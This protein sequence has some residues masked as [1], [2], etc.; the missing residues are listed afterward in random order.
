M[1]EKIYKAYQE[2][3]QKIS[4]D[5]RKVIPGSIFFA[6]K[7]E[8]F[9]GNKFIS[10]AFEKG[11]SY[12][13]IDNSAYAT[14]KTFLVDDV[15][16]TLQHLANYHRKNY[17]F[18]IIAITGTNGKTTTKE[19]IY[20]VLSVKYKCSATQGNL[21]NHL[22]VPLT[23]LSA[24]PDTEILIV[25]MGANHI[26]EIKSLCEIANPDM[27]IITNIGR[28][29]LEGFGGF[30]NVIKAKSELYQ[31]LIDRNLP[32]FV[33]GQDKLL[34]KIIN[35]YSTL[36]SYGDSTSPCFATK[37]HFNKTLLLEVS[38][39]N[40]T[41]K[42]STQ[43][44]GK[45]NIDNILAALCIGQY[46]EVD[47][48]DAIH[49][50]EN[51][52]PQNNRSQIKHTRNNTL[53]LDGYNANP[54]SMN[55]ALTSFLEIDGSRKMVIIG[56]MNELGKYSTKEHQILLDKLSDTNTIKSYFIGKNFQ[57]GQHKKARIFSN[58]DEFISFIKSNKPEQYLILL[59][60]SRT[61]GLE[62]LV[63]YL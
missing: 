17:N 58:T 28:A 24:H 61:N 14:D 50:I 41:F 56:E 60:G 2:C 27:G 48:T 7:G 5:T 36:Y 23:I 44:F 22:G 57:T 40:Q 6:L 32:I 47:S 45:Y 37:I 55:A 63:D 31:Y 34:K 51:Y 21:N 52:I 62:K 25:E 8:R 43:L 4:T 53:I 15:T 29:H 3:N 30:E 54:T 16:S 33:N 18:N 46:F 26:G 19:L 38:I 49:Q 42:L 39:Q 35:N 11:A 20:S 9:D 59:K 1:I 12:C 13:V 10:E